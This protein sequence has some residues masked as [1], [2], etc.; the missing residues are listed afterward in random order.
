MSVTID[1]VSIGAETDDRRLVLANAQAAR[2]IN[3]G[4]SWTQIRIGVRFAFDDTGA[5]ILTNPGFWLGM[6]AS[7]S[8]SMANGPLT[9]A[10]SHFVG[11]L[12]TQ[13][14]W[15]RE[16]APNTTYRLTSSAGG[17]S[18]KRVGNTTTASAAGGGKNTTW[19]SAVPAS[20]RNVHG[21]EITKG[22]PN[23]NIRLLSAV[24]APVTDITSAQFLTAM[25]QTTIAQAATYLQSLG[26]S[27][28]STDNDNIA[29]SEA[30][31]GFLNAICVAW[32]RTPNSVHISDIAWIKVA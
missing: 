12:S 31:D 25:G 21:V 23:F 22:A 14:T 16:N 32:N 30:T 8:A 11:F 27:Y 20:R 15:T 28:T 7:P 17:T 19:V 1:T 5:D 29:V 6:L 3:I 26:S 2:V 9:A 4:T 10:T 18:V 24:S 13:A